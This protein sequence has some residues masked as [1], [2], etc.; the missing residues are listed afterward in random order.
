MQAAVYRRYGTAEVL[1]IEE[2]DRPEVG[3]RDVLIRVRATS[4]NQA[5]WHTMTGT[6]LV[7]RI[8][9]GL[10][11][12]KDEMLGGDF[13]G[14]VDAVGSAVTRF[15][16]GDA[17]FGL[18]R[19]GA[20][21]EYV[22]VPEDRGAVAKPDNVSFEEAG[23]VGVAGITAVQALRTHG[24]LRAGEKVLING[25]SGGVGTF[26]VQVAKAMGAEVAAV[27]SAR[28]VEMARSL[29]AERVFDYT[30]EDFTRSGER[31]DL[32]IDIAGSRSWGECKR[33]M[34]PEARLVVVGGPSRNVLLGPVSHLVGMRL[35]AIGDR[36]KIA[37][38]IATVRDEDLEFLG[39]LLQKGQVKPVIER[40]YDFADIGQAMAYLG[41]GHARAKVAVT[42]PGADSRD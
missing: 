11:G 14:T 26:A 1:K 35:A 32:F 25:A 12:P 19:S 5:D 40:R 29:G 7:A 4:I 13:A 6:P 20:F 10:R 22:C 8:A 9:F 41:E 34:K 36:R 30:K 23:T 24:G 39:E 17:V 3:E 28:N 37:V 38:F 27:C 16:S 2:V 15:K 31:Y 21:A 18:T 33:V 42:I